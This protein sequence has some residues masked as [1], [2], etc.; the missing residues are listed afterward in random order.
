[1]IDAFTD[2][3]QATLSKLTSLLPFLS[4]QIITILS[5]RACDALLPVRSIPSQFRAMS[6]KRSPTEP[7]YFV[8]SILRPV[9][10]FFGI[11][12]EG[13]GLQLKERFLHS[14]ATEVFQNVSQRFLQPSCSVTAEN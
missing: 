12:G 10:I 14:Y 8:S 13:P 11:I 7:S 6:N 9:K 3:L 2:V 5:R 4:N 1:M